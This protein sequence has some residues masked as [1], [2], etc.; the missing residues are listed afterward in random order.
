M[1]VL[2]LKEALVVHFRSIDLPDNAQWRLY[3]RYSI[4]GLFSSMTFTFIRFL[5]SFILFVFCLFFQQNINY[6][7]FWFFL[8]DETNTRELRSFHL[9]IQLNC[10]S[11]LE[12]LLQ[13]LVQ[14][15]WIGTQCLHWFNR[16]MEI[17][18]RNVKIRWRLQLC[19][20]SMITMNSWNWQ[21]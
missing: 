6:V 13:T 5:F 14:V 19:T 21:C 7:T 10:W 4:V 9:T 17:K 8:N 15:R 18:L 11:L 20:T 2:V 1:E 16:M 3:H 12:R